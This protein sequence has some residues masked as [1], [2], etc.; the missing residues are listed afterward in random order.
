[1]VDGSTSQTRTTG[2]LMSDLLDEGRTLVRQELRLARS[3]MTRKGKEI[4]GGAGMLG[5]AAVFASF[6]FAAL[7]ACFVAALSL[8]MPVWTAALIVSL[9][10]AGIAA[11]LGVLGRR[12]VGR[13]AP[14]VPDEAVASVKEDLEWVKHQLR[15]VKR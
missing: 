1:M 7:T 9:A 12:A 11:V 8:V 2:Q 14:P 15:S 10:Y 4:A 6:A 5:A 13:A 3:E